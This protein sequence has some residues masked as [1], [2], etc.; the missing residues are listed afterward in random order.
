MANNGPN[1][2]GSQFFITLKAASFLDGKHVVFGEILEDEGQGMG[3]IDQILE[4]IDIDPKNHRP[5][6]S[7]SRVVIERCGEV[8]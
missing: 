1:A 6:D 2:N 8:A 5:N 3:A 4:I 7:T